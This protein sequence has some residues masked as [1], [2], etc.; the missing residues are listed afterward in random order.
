M[1]DQFNT[2]TIK[3]KKKKKK[4]SKTKNEKGYLGAAKLSNQFDN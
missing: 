3:K 2:Q 4:K 1:Y